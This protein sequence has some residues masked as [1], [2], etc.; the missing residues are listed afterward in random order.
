MP[1]P[2]GSLLWPCEQT[3]LEGAEEKG[4]HAATYACPSSY[5]H[6]TSYN[7]RTN[8]PYFDSVSFFMK[9][10]GLDEGFPE[11]AVEQ[12]E[13]CLLGEWEGSGTTVCPLRGKQGDCSHHPF[14]G[15]VNASL[16]TST[17]QVR[18]EPGGEAPGEEVCRDAASGWT[19]P[20]ESCSGRT[21]LLEEQLPLAASPGQPGWAE[22]QP[23]DG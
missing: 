14:P 9:L 7:R 6:P 13:F 19:I 15:G 16:P 22:W 4:K 21:M 23:R 5:L 18:P 11:D 12:A 1:L 3:G 2:S 8:F 17:W 10:H 20:G